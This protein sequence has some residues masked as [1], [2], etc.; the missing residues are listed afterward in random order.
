[1]CKQANIIF[2]KYI[3]RKEN[4]RDSQSVLLIIIEDTRR[5]IDI[6]KDTV[7]L[8]GSTNWKL[9]SLIIF[10]QIEINGFT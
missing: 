6:Q 3:E 4:E 10:I 8:G 2:P 9:Y 7:D 1:M 5:G